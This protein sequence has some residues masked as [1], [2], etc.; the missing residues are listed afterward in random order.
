[1]QKAS[2][3]LLLAALAS[4]APAQQKQTPQEELVALRA[5]KL[6]KEVF[7][8]APWLADYDEA[9]KTAKATGKIVFAYFTR[10]YAH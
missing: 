10:S 4:L 2:V 3:P 1:M 6:A 8:K 9:R 5:E 7:R